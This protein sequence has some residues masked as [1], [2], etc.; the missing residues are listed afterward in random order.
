MPRLRYASINAT[1]QRWG[2]PWPTVK[3]WCIAGR[4]P[5]VIVE[6]GR[7]RIPTNANL[8]DVRPLTAAELAE[9][10]RR[11]MAG[12]AVGSRSGY[13]GVYR[14]H[15]NWAAIIVVAGKPVHIGTYATREE[16]ARAWDAR[17]R[18]LRGPDTWVNFP[19]EGERSGRNV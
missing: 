2:R 12:R 16:A 4:I 19:A 15:G 1:A 18:E 10:K 13:R 6:N 8:A 7:Y 9:H 14:R 3:N 11:R 17:A 5:G